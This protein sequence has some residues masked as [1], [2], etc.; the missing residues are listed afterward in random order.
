MLREIDT[1][2]R[3]CPELGTL[4]GQ[5]AELRSRLSTAGNAV[6]GASALTAAELAVLPLL[7][8]HLTFRE[9][10]ERRYLSKYTVKSHAMSIYRKLGVTSR[11][12]AV[13]RARE[14]GLL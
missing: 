5:M 3:R 12:A 8:T 13:D 1:V 11:S 9:I 6:P 10:G 14:A 4:P 2:L 7:T